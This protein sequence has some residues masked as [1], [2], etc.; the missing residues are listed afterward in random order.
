MSDRSFSLE[1]AASEVRVR[2]ATIMYWLRNLADV[3][4][5]LSAR[6]IPPQF[7]PADIDLLRSI[8]ALALDAGY[9]AR[10][11]A[12]TLG[13]WSRQQEQGRAHVEELIHEVRALRE[14]IAFLAE[15]SKELHRMLA[16]LLEFTWQNGAA[17]SGA[18]EFS[19]S[20]TASRPAPGV[21]V[22]ALARSDSSLRKKGEDRLRGRQETQPWAP[23][24][25]R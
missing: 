23:P 6:N 7:D 18:E 2:P 5:S 8:R 13:A 15:E 12:L 25:L 11:I 9:P 22:G 1:Q 20:K 4:F 10:R 14:E 16:L 3:P 17:G 19:H 24:V 21:P